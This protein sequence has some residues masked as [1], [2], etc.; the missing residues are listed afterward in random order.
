MLI[1]IVIV[2]WDTFVA[3]YERLDAAAG[4]AQSADGAFEYFCPMHPA[5]VRDDPNEKCPICFM[6]LSKRKKGT[7]K[8]AALPPG[9]VNRVDLTPYRMVLA[10]V[11]T[12]Q[13]KYVPLAKELTTVGFVEFNERGLKQ[14]AARVKG[15]LDT[16]SV[17]ETG[18]EVHAGQVL[19][20]LYSPD[21]VVTVQNLLEAQRGQNA[22]LV[23]APR[24]LKAVGHQRRSGRGNPADR[25]GQHASQHSLPHRWPRPQKIRQG[26]T[27]RQRRHAALRRGRS[28]NGLDRGSDL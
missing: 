6:P 18:Q 5:V 23:R 12:W 16:L 21:L 27:V 15:R 8:E 17:N 4:T 25:Q 1:G 11:E 7:D 24:A 19:A 2:K 13:V 20:S 9:I 10:G 26:G 14:V 22:N 3:Y 28:V